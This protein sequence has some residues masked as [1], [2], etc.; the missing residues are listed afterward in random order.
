[1][2]DRPTLP[3]PR[4]QTLGGYS[5]AS[6]QGYR[7]KYFKVEEQEGSLME[8]LKPYLPAEQIAQLQNKQN[9]AAQILALQSEHLRK[10]LEQ[11]FIEDFRHMELAR[12]LVELYNQQGASERIKS[13]PYPRQ[14]ASLNFWFIQIFIF[15]LPFGMLQEFERGSKYRPLSCRIDLKSCLSSG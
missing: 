4:K 14:F 3:T 15:L 9:K 12:I 2:A 10:L 11:G 7:N 8:A 1:M 5:L 13:F 6:Q